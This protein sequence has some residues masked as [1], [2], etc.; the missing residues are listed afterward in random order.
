MSTDPDTELLGFG[1]QYLHPEPEQKPIPRHARRRDRSRVVI[2][3]LGGALVVAVGW[4]VFLLLQL[5]AAR[6]ENAAASSEQAELAT[7]LEASQEREA[8]LEAAVAVADEQLSTAVDDLSA[9]QREL[10][11]TEEGAATV[12]E[13]LETT[14]A[15]LG[16]LRRN[17]E[18]L[19]SAVFG[20]VDPVDTCERAADRLADQVDEARRGALRQLAQQAADACTAAAEAV[21]EAVP[22]ASTILSGP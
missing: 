6:D 8:A 21:Q 9:A 5:D 11:E 10:A 7:A 17:A 12:G 18:A 15:A 4:G 14:E 1:A 2:A 16:E 20:S 13:R 3:V 22:R 19:A